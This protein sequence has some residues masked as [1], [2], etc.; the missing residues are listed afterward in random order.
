MNI[1]HIITC[2]GDG[3]AEAVL[4]RL[5]CADK[6]HRHQVVSLMD[7]GK[8]GELLEKE[9]VSVCCLGMQKGR[10]SLGGLSRLWRILR[11]DKWDVVQ[12]WMYHADLV[13]GLLARFAGVPRVFWG[14]RNNI[15]EP[16]KSRRGTMLVVR[17]N[18]W[19]SRWVPTGIVCCAERS[20]QVHQALGFVDEKMTV[21]P[22]GYDTGLFRPDAEKRQRLRSEWGVDEGIPVIGMVGRFDPFKDHENLLRALRLLRQTATRYQCVLVGRGMDPS[23][24]Q[25]AA[26]IRQYDLQDDVLLLGQRGDIPAVMNAID[27]HVLS[28]CSEAFP[29]VLAEAMACGTPCVSTDVGDAHLIVGA[30]GWIVPARNSEI[31]AQAIR[32]TLTEKK[33]RAYWVNRQQ[34]ARER[35]VTKFNIEQMVN[36]YSNL[37]ESG[38]IA[39]SS[40]E[41]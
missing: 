12:T 22:N 30:T 33:N 4:H 9:G 20:R 31:L 32:E 19:L 8:Y 26:W 23:N 38:E 21:I 24:T 6:N 13:G 15:L 27:V 17:F 7:A 40:I 18:A 10:L 1:L 14:I 36:S 25:L 34:A 37:W 11:S 2:L 3:G 16:G 29:N 41:N 5:C 39:H 35:I 28:S